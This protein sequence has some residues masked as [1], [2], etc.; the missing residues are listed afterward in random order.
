MTAVENIAIRTSKRRILCAGLFGLLLAAFL[1]AAANSTIP[2]LIATSSNT[3]LAVAR[4]EY[5]TMGL[6]RFFIFIF[7]C[8]IGSGVAGFLSRRNGVVAGL[9]ASSFNIGLFSFLTYG[10]ISG[11]PLLTAPFGM[12]DTK[13]EV[14]AVLCIV[15]VVA[16]IG[17][18]AGELV[19]TPELDL[20][21]QT[22][23]VT[24]FGIRWWHY[25]WI[26]PIVYLAFVESLIVVVYAWVNVIWKDISY[27]WHPSLWL[28]FS[29]WL[30][31]VLSIVLAHVATVVTVGGL[32][33]FHQ[34]MRYESRYHGWGKLGRVLLYGVGAPA[35]SYPLAALA[36][37]AARAMPTPAQGDWKVAVGLVALFFL[38]AAVVSAASWWQKQ[39]SRRRL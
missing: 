10:A 20:D 17:G 32:A 5:E 21:Q 23:F 7:S 31:L 9:A 30:F 38:I 14:I 26:F 27:A 1:V 12:F 22:E 35:L 2:R 16:A 33:R 19:C 4:S 15:V 36:S 8:A 28:S 37:D 39:S 18:I 11:V 3:D 24:I 34:T 13:V 6:I 29:A 25:F